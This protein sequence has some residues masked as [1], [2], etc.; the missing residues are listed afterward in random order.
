MPQGVSELSVSAELASNDERKATDLENLLDRLVSVRRASEAETEARDGPIFSRSGGIGLGLFGGGWLAS[1]GAT[2]LHLAWLNALAVFVLVLGVVWLV[3]ATIP[4]VRSFLKQFGSLEADTF[5]DV[6]RNL[7]R[8]YDAIPDIRENYSPEQIRFAQE[9]LKAVG[10]DAR[11]R[12]AMFTGALDK[13][14]LIPLVATTIVTLV[15]FNAG[16]N[17]PMYLWYSAAAVAGLLYV[18]MLRL[19]DVAFALERFSLIL[20]YAAE[21]VPK[22]P[23]SGSGDV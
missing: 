13:V 10:S 6:G 9:Y 18:A 14:G 8:W 11:V 7:S 12:M 5:N 3:V 4:T 1:S 15:K 16:E 23:N 20:K 22:P 2:W 17:L 21:D 19:T